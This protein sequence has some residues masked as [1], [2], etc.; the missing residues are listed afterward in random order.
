MG[1]LLFIPQGIENSP[2][3]NINE[4]SIWLEVNE[5]FKRD[6]CSLFDLSFDSLLN[7]RYYLCT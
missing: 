5:L 7:V 4:E 1:T 6:A 2:Y 3:S